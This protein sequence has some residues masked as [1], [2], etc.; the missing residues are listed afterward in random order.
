V[1]AIKAQQEWKNDMEPLEMNISKLRLGELFVDL[2]PQGEPPA[3]RKA[4][5][6]SR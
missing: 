1:T 4:D 5:L 6:H 2:L 3:L